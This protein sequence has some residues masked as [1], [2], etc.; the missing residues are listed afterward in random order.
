MF[1]NFKQQVSLD[2]SAARV[3]MSPRNFARRFSAATGETPLGY[4][5]R[6]RIDAARHLLE[7]RGKSVADVS[8]DV[9]YEDSRLL[10]AS[11]QASH[12]RIAAGLPRPLRPG[13]RARRHGCGAG[14]G[15]TGRQRGL[16]LGF[17]Q[18]TGQ[19]RPSGSCER[20]PAGMPPVTWSAARRPLV[21]KVRS[22]MIR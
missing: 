12:R 11:V 1:R 15:A 21:H 6:L 8:Q 4:L 20:T 13:P 17:G 19:P 22:V 5:H 3:G 9:G 18:A 14:I 2:D 7:T 16:A 10:P